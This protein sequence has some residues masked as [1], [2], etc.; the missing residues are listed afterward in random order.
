MLRVTRPLVREPGDQ[1]KAILELYL[2]SCDQQIQQARIINVFKRGFGIG[3][4]IS[5]N[6]YVL[7]LACDGRR[8]GDP[9][10]TLISISTCTCVTK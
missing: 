5:E 3:V 6:L 4:K 8:R 7:F 1:A 2:R 10:D 9:N